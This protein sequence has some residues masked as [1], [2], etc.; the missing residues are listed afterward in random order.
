MLIRTGDLDI[1]EG[2]QRRA[3][4]KNGE[5]VLCIGNAVT[6]PEANI[7]TI[8]RRDASKMCSAAHVEAFGPGYGE[9]SILH[10]AAFGA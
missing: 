10:M 8:L 9:Y 6:M 5:D 3:E 7:G 1:H 4:D 2:I